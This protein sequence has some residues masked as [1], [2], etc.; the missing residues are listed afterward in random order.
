MK[1]A[2]LEKL[3]ISELSKIT[4]GAVYTDDNCAHGGSDYSYG[5]NDGCWTLTKAGDTASSYSAANCF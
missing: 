2:K 3:T 1:T 5:G 4:G